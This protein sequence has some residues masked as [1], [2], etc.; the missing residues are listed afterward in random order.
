LE[1]HCTGLQLEDFAVLAISYHLPANA[2]HRR[3]MASAVTRE[4][5]NVLPGNIRVLT[6]VRVDGRGPREA[7]RDLRLRRD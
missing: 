7:F 3:M 4:R 1:D 2:L 6:D 5:T